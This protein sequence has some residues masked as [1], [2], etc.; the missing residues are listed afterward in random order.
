[1]RL[2]T[3]HH[4]MTRLRICPGNIRLFL[5]LFRTQSE[6]EKYRRKALAR[7]LP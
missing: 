2:S 5:G 3:T 4:N 7:K 1:M 6:H